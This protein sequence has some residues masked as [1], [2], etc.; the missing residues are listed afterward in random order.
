MKPFSVRN[1]KLTS[2]F[3]VQQMSLVRE[4]EEEKTC[5][6]HSEVVTSFEKKKKL[7]FFGGGGPVVQAC[8][9]GIVSSV[10]AGEHPVCSSVTCLCM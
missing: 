3:S 1:C 10:I 5:R 2:Y 9:A 6:V 4:E 7:F 8:R